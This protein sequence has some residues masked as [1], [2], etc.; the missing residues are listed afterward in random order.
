MF[1]NEKILKPDQTQ[2]IRMPATSDPIGAAIVNDDVVVIYVEDPTT[3]NT[4]IVDFIIMKTGDEIDAEV[5]SEFSYL[6]SPVT[7]TGT[8]LN[9][10][11]RAS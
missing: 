7:E 5:L 11:Y 8:I 2:T 10:F 4:K 6:G 9:V 1:F 3:P